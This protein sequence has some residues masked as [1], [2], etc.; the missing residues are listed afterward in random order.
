MNRDEGLEFLKKVRPL[1][2]KNERLDVRY[3]RVNRHFDAATALGGNAELSFADYQS[4]EETMERWYVNG[5]LSQ[6]GWVKGL[7]NTS[8]MTH[9]CSDLALGE[10]DRIIYSVIESSPAGVIGIGFQTVNTPEWTLNVGNS[11]IEQAYVSRSWREWTANETIAGLMGT[12]DPATDDMNSIGFIVKDNVCSQPFLDALGTSYSWT[13]PK[14]TV[15][16]IPERAK[17]H[18]LELEEIEVEL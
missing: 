2:L 18:V 16:T 5:K 10:G 12:I 1:D 17:E 13:S 3:E 8:E 9:T 6:T 4:L 14:D 15:A 7:G 11:E